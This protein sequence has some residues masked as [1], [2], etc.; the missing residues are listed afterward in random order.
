MRTHLIS[1]SL[2]TAV[3]ILAV[4]G[5]TRLEA[6]AVQSAPPSAPPSALTPSV[7][8]SPSPSP[9]DTASAAQQLLA[10]LLSSQPHGKASAAAYVVTTY[11]AFEASLAPESRLP[12]S[13]DAATHGVIVLKVFGSFPAAHRGAPGANT[14]ATTIVAV[15]DTT[16]DA[17]VDYTYYT[18]PEPADLPGAQASTRAEY[19]DLRT[20]GTPVA[21]AP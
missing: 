20:L 6:G 19:A 15:Y 1:R 13:A 3:V 5:C 12:M 2:A 11:G 9:T 18:G 17:V 16:T 7:A 21:L 8:P 14:D 4:G 10:T